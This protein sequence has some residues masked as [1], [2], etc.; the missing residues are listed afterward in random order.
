MFRVCSKDLALSLL[1]PRAAMLTEDAKLNELIPKAT[2]WEIRRRGQSRRNSR[3]KESIKG[4]GRE[5]E[6]ERDTFL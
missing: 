5:E 2:S 1:G 4:E 6:I 3:L